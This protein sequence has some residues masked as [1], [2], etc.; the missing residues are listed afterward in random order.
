MASSYPTGLDT[1]ATNKSDNTPTAG[2][3]AQH[4]DDLADAINKVEAE[5]GIN[6]SGSLSD[7]VS[8]MGV[9]SNSDGT[10]KTTAVQTAI[11]GAPPA[12]A[13]W[14]TGQQNPWLAWN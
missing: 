14:G 10:L 9:A 8:R 11:G 5:L 13:T 4:H 2:D 3:H 12:T 1:L 6:P 7:V